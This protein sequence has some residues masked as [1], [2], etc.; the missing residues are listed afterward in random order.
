[1]LRALIFGI[2]LILALL[3]E[4]AFSVRLVVPMI[5]AMGLVMPQRRLVVWSFVA[6]LLVDLVRGGMLGTLVIFYLILGAVLVLF[7]SK[8]GRGNMVLVSFLVAIL[9]AGEMLFLGQGFRLGLIGLSVGAFWLLQVVNVWLWSFE[10]SR[11]E[12]RL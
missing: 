5:V 1:M 10:E 12:L 4:V 9:V 7:L 6:G 3:Q 2:I 11:G 8:V